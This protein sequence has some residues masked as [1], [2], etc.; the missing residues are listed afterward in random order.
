MP[1][2]CLYNRYHGGGYYHHSSSSYFFSMF[3]F[4]LILCGIGACLFYGRSMAEPEVVMVQPGYAQGYAVGPN[5]QPV[6]MQG[7]QTVV[8]QGG[9]YGGCAHGGR[10]RGRAVSR[11]RHARQGHMHHR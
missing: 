11:A 9:G 6:P 8:V 4:L 3:M 2:E 5:G 7:G 1:Q 10:V